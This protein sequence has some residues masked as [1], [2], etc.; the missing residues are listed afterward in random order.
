MEKRTRK[1]D[2]PGKKDDPSKRH[3]GAMANTG[4]NQ[5]DDPTKPSQAE[6][7][8]ATVDASLREKEKRDRA[9]H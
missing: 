6:G 1:S 3:T 2:Q 5:S 7:S 8:R 9:E 4:R